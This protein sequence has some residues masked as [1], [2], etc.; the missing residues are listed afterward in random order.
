MKKFL[1]IGITLFTTQQALCME[2]ETES[3]AQQGEEQAAQLPNMAVNYITQIIQPT[4]KFNLQAINQEFVS[5]E[6]EDRVLFWYQALKKYAS[7]S[8]ESALGERVAF[9]KVLEE[10]FHDRNAAGEC[11]TALAQEL[12]EK[13]DHYTAS[14]EQKAFPRFFKSWW[15][16]SAKPQLFAGLGCIALGYTLSS[17]ARA[18]DPLIQT[19]FVA[20]CFILSAGGAL[21][22]S[23][24]INAQ[25]RATRSIKNLADILVASATKNYA[26]TTNTVITQPSASQAQSADQ[27][28]GE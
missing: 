18:E 6:P 9:G 21:V 13:I 22:A 11:F 8:D 14:D 1:L 3:G 20:P 28:N 26:I 17:F 4:V 10:K 24:A 23:T 27:D 7:L 2:F 25:Y 19:L 12:Q 15:R 5:Q 16:S